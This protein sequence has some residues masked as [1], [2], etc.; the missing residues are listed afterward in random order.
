[1]DSMVL[2][3]ETLCSLMVKLLSEDV[4]VLRRR[5]EIVVHPY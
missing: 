3:F 1:M 5:H 4:E 2:Y